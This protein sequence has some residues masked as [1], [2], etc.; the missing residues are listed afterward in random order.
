MKVAFKCGV[1][2]ASMRE[3]RVCDVCG[4]MLCPDCA[5]R[6]VEGHAVVCEMCAGTLRAAAGQDELEEPT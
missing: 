5:H 3:A 1:C 2:A 4:A 6:W